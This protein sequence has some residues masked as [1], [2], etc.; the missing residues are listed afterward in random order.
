MAKFLAM[1]ASRSD[2]C[3]PLIVEDTETGLVMPPNLL[4]LYAWCEASTSKTT[5]QDVDVHEVSIY[6]L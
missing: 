4:G 3:H 5:R 2:R 1:S 6:S